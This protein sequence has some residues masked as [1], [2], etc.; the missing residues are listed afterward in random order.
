MAAGTREADAAWLAMPRAAIDLV[1]Q[2]TRF[3]Q[4]S[5]GE[6]DVLNHEKVS[7]YLESTIMQ[8]SYKVGMFF[9]APWWSPGHI[10]R[11][12]RRLRDHAGD[13]RGS[14]ARAVP[15]VGAEGHGI[16]D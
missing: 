9:D 5:K 8:P 7:L 14:E 10:P 2:A 1:A 16:G 6:V 12:D 4:P 13:H 11:A 3:R 15:G